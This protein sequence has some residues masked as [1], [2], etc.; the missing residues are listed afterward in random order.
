M[1]RI[2]AQ[3]PRAYQDPNPLTVFKENSFR[4][5]WPHQKII[6]SLQSIKQINKQ[7]LWMYF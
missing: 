2:Q 3:G 4:Y 5:V 7:A 6:L 1:K